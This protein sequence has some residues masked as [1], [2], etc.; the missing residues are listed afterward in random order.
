MDGFG[1]YHPLTAVENHCYG[2][3]M[4][5]ST[6]VAIAALLSALAAPAPAPS[7]SPGARVL[8][9]TVTK[10]FRHDSIPDLERLVADIAQKG[11]AF[12]VD[13]AR[14][15]D[16][17]KDK[18]TEAALARTD[19]LV[20]A[21]TTGDLPVADREALLRWIE[22]GHA[23]VGIHAASDTFHGFTPYL[24]LLGGEFEHH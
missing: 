4:L 14:T 16:E 1:V 11:G 15:D 5:T 22:A 2:P 17:L 7:P 20:F 18:T 23:L 19:A 6:T 13:Y 21:S 3:P 8:V 10:G 9:V 24:D 12:T